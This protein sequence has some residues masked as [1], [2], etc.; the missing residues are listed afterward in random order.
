MRPVKLQLTVK[1]LQH[2]ILDYE[3]SAS[4]WASY[5]SNDT[6]QNLASRYFAWKVNRK[7]GRLIK[8]K[9]YETR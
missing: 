1:E 8:L 9:R 6:L 2:V 4:W 7:I 5:V 3:I